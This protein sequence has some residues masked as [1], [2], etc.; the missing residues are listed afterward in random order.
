M[1]GST[2]ANFSCQ[3]EG[4]QAFEN[5][6]I[7][8]VS[9]VQDP[10]VHRLPSQ[11]PYF[12]EYRPANLIQRRLKAD[13]ASHANPLWSEHVIAQRIAEQLS[14]YF[15]VSQEAMRSTFVEPSPLRNVLEIESGGRSI[16][17]FQDSKHLSNYADAVGLEFLNSHGLVDLRCCAA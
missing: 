1:D 14:L 13:A 17:E 2:H 3:P 7:Q 9:P 15:E 11:P 10:Q 16:Q 12:F 4:V 8:D 6:K 5:V